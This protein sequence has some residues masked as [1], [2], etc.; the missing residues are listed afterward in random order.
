M[1]A[2]SSAAGVDSHDETSQGLVRGNDL[3]ELADTP[4]DENNSLTS[5]LNLGKIGS[6]IGQ[7]CAVTLILT[8][9]I[10]GYQVNKGLNINNV[11]A[12]TQAIEDWESPYLYYIVGSEYTV[13]TVD[14]EEP[15]VAKKEKRKPSKKVRG[16]T[17]P[18]PNDLSYVD[19]VAYWPGTSA[20]KVDDDGDVSAE[21]DDE[22]G[23]L[24][25][26]SGVNQTTLFGN[27]F[28]DPGYMQKEI[29]PYTRLNSTIG[30]VA[31]D[32]QC[33]IGTNPCIT[34][35]GSS[36]SIG[37]V[38]YPPKNQTLCF[39]EENFD[40]CPVVDVEIYNV[41]DITSPPEIQIA[42]EDV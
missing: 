10:L 24:S 12:Y 22:D 20:G 37:S 1:G 15:A 11:T 26:V 35:M 3:N 19:V 5:G 17:K 29:E 42:L 21:S 40:F 30:V 7:G 9:G 25:P 18:V 33:P 16:G 14:S 4:F 28:V 39:T 31:S 36:S 34:A 2:S 32:N 6:L 38:W 8:I 27:N 41:T 23:N 13:P